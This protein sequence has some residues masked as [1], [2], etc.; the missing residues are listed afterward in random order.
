MTFIRNK[1]RTLIWAFSCLMIMCSVL[2]MG[3]GEAK[4]LTLH[5]A[6]DSL[7]LLRELEHESGKGFMRARAC[8]LGILKDY[9]AQMEDRHRSIL[10]KLP[11]F[12]KNKVTEQLKS[13]VK[14]LEGNEAGG[15][16]AERQI[17]AASKEIAGF[18]SKSKLLTSEP[19][20]TFEPEA[21]SKE[22]QDTLEE[23]LAVA[24]DKAN[25]Y[26]SEPT[27]S[28]AEMA[29]QTNRKAVTYLYISRFGYQKIVSQEDLKKLQTDINRAIYYNRSLQKTD[30]T[31][32]E[33]ERSR[34]NEYS[35]SEVH[36]LRLLQSIIN[37]DIREAQ[38][39]LLKAIR[40]AFPDHRA[41][42]CYRDHRAADLEV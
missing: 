40:E 8:H 22:I 42:C 1:A 7:M 2:L 15:T 37:N 30:E 23:S 19:I 32:N 10:L 27:V 11:P 36:R 4:K 28:N 38:V 5:N 17:K 16:N 33:E 9:V 13:V 31:I 41:A 12:S 6:T 25:I 3:A 20:I 29:C 21:M 24:H 34:L 39:L 14:I 26:A 35:K 18:L